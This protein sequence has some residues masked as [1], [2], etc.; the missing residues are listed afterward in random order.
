MFCSIIKF[1]ESDSVNEQRIIT[2]S[3]IIFDILKIFSKNLK[4]TEILVN[5]I[6]FIKLIAN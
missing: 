4:F 2:I 6:E 1:K 5:N 3:S